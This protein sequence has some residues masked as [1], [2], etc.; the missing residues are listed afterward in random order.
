M[1][2]FSEQRQCLEMVLM[3]K[4]QYSLACAKCPLKNQCPL[5]I[6]ARRPGARHFTQKLFIYW[7]HLCIICILTFRT[8]CGIIITS[9]KERKNL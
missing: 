5:L 1:E 3:A 7:P 9:K 4:G 2:K 6:G 8:V